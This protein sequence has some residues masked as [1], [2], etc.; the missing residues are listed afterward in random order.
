MDDE[1]LKSLMEQSIPKYAINCFS[2]DTPQIV[3]QMKTTG[4]KTT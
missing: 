2:Y 3:V 1:E 4:D